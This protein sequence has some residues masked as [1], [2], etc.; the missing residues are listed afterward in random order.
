MRCAHILKNRI[1]PTGTM[2]CQK[3]MM[4]KDPK[5]RFMMLNSVTGLNMTLIHMYVKRLDNLNFDYLNIVLVFN[6]CP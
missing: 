3:T 5:I 1:Q 2:L 4:H 6:I